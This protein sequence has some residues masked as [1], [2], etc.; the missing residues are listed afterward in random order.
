MQADVSHAARIGNRHLPAP[1]MD[2]GQVLELEAIYKAHNR[3][4]LCIHEAV[5]VCVKSG[6]YFTNALIREIMTTNQ[7][8][9]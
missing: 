1:P 5:K 6:R 2:A 9:L 8:Q 3:L 7:R 4:F